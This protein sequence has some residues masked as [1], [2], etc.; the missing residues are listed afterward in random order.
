MSVFQFL[1]IYFNNT[2]VVHIQNI[3]VAE[4]GNGEENPQANIQAFIR[5]NNTFVNQKGEEVGMEATL[6]QIVKEIR[7]KANIRL[8]PAKKQFMG[9]CDCEP[10]M[11]RNVVTCPL[12]SPP[13]ELKNMDEVKRIIVDKYIKN[14]YNYGDMQA[15]AIDIHYQWT[16]R[17][18]KVESNLRQEIVSYLECDV[19]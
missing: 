11:L 1:N 17:A 15:I 6:H 12:S 4:S 19:F 3:T 16:W 7:Y 9:K 13:P 14:E 10:S 2:Y 8:S 5:F 18:A